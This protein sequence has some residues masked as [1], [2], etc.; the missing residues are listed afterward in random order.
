MLH[1]FRINAELARL[2]SALEKVARL[3][4][5]DPVYAPI[6]LRLEQEIT[7]VRLTLDAVDRARA[8]VRNR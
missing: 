7:K 3:V 8:L 5:L 4:L 2:E 1:D 6:F